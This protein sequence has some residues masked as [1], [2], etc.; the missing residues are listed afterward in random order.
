MNLAKQN[1]APRNPDS[2]QVVFPSPY[3]L[4]KDDEA[5]L[6]QFATERREQLSR[7]LGLD[8]VGKH[9]WWAGESYDSVT[10]AAKSWLGKRQVYELTYENE[11]EWRRHVFGEIFEKSNWHLPITRRVVS[12][13]VARASAHFCGSDPWFFADVVQSDDQD[14]QQAAER[15]LR[16]K[17]EDA[18]IRQVLEAAIE[19]AFVRGEAVLKRGH[20]RETDIYE[21]EIEIMLTAGGQPIYDARGEYVLKSTPVTVATTEA[22]PAPVMG[23]AKL[24]GS[25]PKPAPVKQVMTLADGTVIEPGYKYEKRIVPRRNV[26]FDGP[27]LELCYFKDILI[28]LTAKDIDSADCIVHLYDI[29][30]ADLADQW[31][32]EAN[33]IGEAERNIDTRTAVEAIRAMEGNRGSGGEGYDSASSLNRVER[34]EDEFAQHS[35]VSTHPTSATAKIAEYWLRYDANGDGIMENIV[36]VMDRET[37]TPIYYDYVANVTPDGK[38]PFSVVR[39][40]PVDGRWYGVGSMQI[41]EQ[42]QNIS[43]LLVNRWNVSSGKAGRVD[44]L[45]RHAIEGGETDPDIEINVWGETLSLKE[46]M[47]AED[48]L[49]FVSLPEVKADDLKN[50]LDLYGQMAMNMSGVQHANDAG[51][52]GLQS[53]RTATSIINLDKSGHEMFGLLL[54][55]LEP[56]IVGTINAE[57]EIVVVNMS[58]EE[59][60]HWEED[61]RATYGTIARSALGNFRIRIRLTLSKYKAE[62]E[63]LDLGNVIAKGNEFYAMVDPAA[64]AALAPLYRQY[65]R[66]HGV[67]NPEA[68]F[69]DHH[70]PPGM[71]ADPSANVL[72]A[73]MDPMPH[74]DETK[75]PDPTQNIS[76]MSAGIAGGLQAVEQQAAVTP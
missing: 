20:R 16:N 64:R 25:D 24:F 57:A 47:K 67:K 6:I 31:N 13:Q 35:N 32:R 29:P 48:A 12:Q 37:N 39:I 59:V 18:G 75:Q 70:S 76:Q 71:P 15:L 26:L 50:M 14:L 30:V 63:K 56:G 33:G 72:A 55:H 11:V 69:V 65:A 58:E 36:L 41:Y 23:I 17:F 73:P 43:D 42:I 28:P 62:Q 8:R 3:R 2:P 10:Q 60:Y 7:E 21:A 74:G 5:K 53:A 40:N 51:Q 38:R 4:S 66:H 22:A 1:P 27:S 61:D 34:P 45:N 46:N 9:D 54:G 44:F 68:V 49:S 19:R 52:A